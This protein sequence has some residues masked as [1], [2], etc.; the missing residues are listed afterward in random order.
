MT[1][2]Y[3]QLN[4]YYKIYFCQDHAYELPDASELRKRVAALDK[5]RQRLERELRNVREREKRAKN[6]CQSLL[7]DLK[8]KNLLTAELHAKLDAYSGIIV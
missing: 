8:E 7:K 6:T 4:N 5:Q 2:Y 3:I 1:G